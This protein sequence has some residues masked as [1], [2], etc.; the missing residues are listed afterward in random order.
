M[1]ALAGRGLRALVAK[2]MVAEVL[3]PVWGS[4]RVRDAEGRRPGRR[5]EPETFSA[6]S[7]V[8]FPIPFKVLT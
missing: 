1:R 3:R 5:S 8:K 6:S 7:I 4:E 2:K